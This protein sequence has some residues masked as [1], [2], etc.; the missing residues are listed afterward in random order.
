VEDLSAEV[1][2]HPIERYRRYLRRELPPLVRRE[3]TTIVDTALEDQLRER[4][5]QLVQSLHSQ[6][7]DSFRES[8]ICESLASS[9]QPIPI[10][11]E[12]AIISFE[13]QPAVLGNSVASNF[14]S[15]GNVAD[16]FDDQPLA[17]GALSW[18]FASFD[19]YYREGMGSV[20]NPSTD[21]A[22]MEILSTNDNN[23]TRS[24]SMGNA[25]TEWDW[26]ETG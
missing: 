8:I 10:E 12:V 2:L 26:E 17:A 18:D 20:T 22:G 16:V 9:L 3:L 21:V 24:S 25:S 19:S 4:I 1:H 23:D 5:V 14:P 15:F 6:L 11:N 13:A 7:Y